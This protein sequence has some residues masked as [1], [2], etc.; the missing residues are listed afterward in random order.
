[1]NTPERKVRKLDRFLNELSA[2]WTPV[3]D[4]AAL[5][6]ITAEAVERYL[7]VGGRVTF[8]RVAPDASWSEVEFSHA[9]GGISVTG[10]YSLKEFLTETARAEFVAGNP[11][12]IADANGD[13]RTDFARHKYQQ[14]H[15]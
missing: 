8:G 4:A 13:S 12:I 1:M 10:T 15:V 7:Q 6:Q 5:V 9:Y 11:L 14:L 2:S 3:R